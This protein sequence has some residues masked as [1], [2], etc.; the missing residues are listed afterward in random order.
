MTMD[1]LDR[2]RMCPPRYPSD[3]TGPGQ[4]EV[5]ETGDALLG[6][7]RQLTRV[8]RLDGD[9]V[10]ARL[11]LHPLLQRRRQR[12]TQGRVDVDRHQV[13][14]DVAL[15]DLHCRDEQRPARSID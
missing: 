3:R 15:L 11:A 5:L 12:V 9:E 7:R 6:E 14:A 2:R 13:K 4:V 8:G 10:E 1:Q